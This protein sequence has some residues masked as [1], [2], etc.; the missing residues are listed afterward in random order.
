MNQNHPSEEV[1]NDWSNKQTATQSVAKVIAITNPSLK[2]FV[3]ADNIIG[4]AKARPVKTHLDID[5]E[6]DSKAVIFAKRALKTQFHLPPRQQLALIKALL[7]ERSNVNAALFTLIDDAS[8]VI[9]DHNRGNS[10]DGDVTNIGYSRQDAM[11]IYPKLYKD[12][13]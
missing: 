1:V 7:D 5:K 9:H 11:E 8:N 10:L 3:T 13:K 6:I 12:K 4:V 2:P